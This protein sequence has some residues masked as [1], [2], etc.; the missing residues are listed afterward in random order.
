MSKFKINYS[1]ISAMHATSNGNI[2]LAGENGD[3][4]R[5]LVLID[6]TGRILWTKQLESE[7]S[8]VTS[9]SLASTP[10][11]TLAFN[12]GCKIDFYDMKRKDAILFSLDLKG[13]KPG[14]LGTKG[15]MLSYVDW[16]TAP[17]S[18]Q[19]ID[20][21]CFPP[22]VQEESES[23]ALS[24][25]VIADICFLQRGNML[26]A[27]VSTDKA[28]C[29]YDVRSGGVQWQISGKIGTSKEP[30]YPWGVCTDDKGHIFVAD[31]S[32]VCIHLILG[33][34]S[35]AK[36]ILNDLSY[37]QEVSWDKQHGR[38]IVQHEEVNCE[39]GSDDNDCTINTFQ[40][41]YK[42]ASSNLGKFVGSLFGSS[43]GEWVE[44]NIDTVKYGFSDIGKA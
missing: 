28:L 38:L 44:D 22:E 4:V 30:L 26:L 34:G 5:W 7:Q 27:I 8:G 36:T 17:H 9:I 6:Q 40:V 41:S 42:V 23:I 31:R 39:S 18:L 12:E 11:L 33:N 16:S 1:I 20:C 35:F 21:S 43:F 25:N 10:C 37:V 3:G 14:C 32:N 15:H 19:F 24:D 13:H 2:I 29:A